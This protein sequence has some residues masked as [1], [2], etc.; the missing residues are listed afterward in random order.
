MILLGRWRGRWMVSMLLVLVR[1]RRGNAVMMGRRRVMRRW[2][3]RS[4][5]RMR[6]VVVWGSRSGSSWCRIT[7]V[8]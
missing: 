3:G 5:V 1:R 8:I 2:R 7:M 4:R 6:I